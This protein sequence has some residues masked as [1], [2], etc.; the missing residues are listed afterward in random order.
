M[1]DQ[2]RL[3]KIEI[4]LVGILHIQGVQNMTLGALLAVLNQDIENLKPRTIGYLK[5]ITIDHERGKAIIK[6]A[7]ALID[8]LKDAPS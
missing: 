4:A 8:E 1:T 5:Q 3:K 2:G 6:D 7:I